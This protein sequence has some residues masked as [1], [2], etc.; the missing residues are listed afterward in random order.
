M[1][2][3]LGV[4]VCQEYNIHTNESSKNIKYLHQLQHELFDAG[5]K[6]KIEL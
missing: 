4:R 3:P 1:P 5:V 2:I 6:L